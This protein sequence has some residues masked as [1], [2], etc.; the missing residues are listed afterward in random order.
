M[1][2]ISINYSV[3]FEA[4][5]LVWILSSPC[6][7]WLCMQSIPFMIIENLFPKILHSSFLNPEIN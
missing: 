1:G 2:L 3:K 6:S 7:S 4:P 5:L